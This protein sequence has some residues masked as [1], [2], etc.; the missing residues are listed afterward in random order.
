MSELWFSL[1]EEIRCVIGLVAFIAL[2]LLICAVSDV[3]GAKIDKRKNETH[4][5]QTE[6]RNES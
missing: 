3:I 2:W 1:S 5:T 4:G 6:T